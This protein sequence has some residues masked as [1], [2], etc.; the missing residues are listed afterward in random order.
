M[1]VAHGP[2]EVY[3]RNTLY[4]AHSLFDSNT[5]INITHSL[6]ITVNTIQLKPNTK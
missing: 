6:C 5:L 3:I 1:N 4:I 2:N